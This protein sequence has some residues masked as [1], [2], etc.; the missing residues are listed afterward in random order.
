MKLAED[1]AKTAFGPFFFDEKTTSQPDQCSWRR[2]SALWVANMA[3][4]LL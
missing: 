3:G 4:V 1:F 2:K